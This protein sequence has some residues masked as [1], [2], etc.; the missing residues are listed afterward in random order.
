MS[1]VQRTLLNSESAALVVIDIQE[2]LAA[3]MDRRDEVVASTTRLLKTAAMLEMPIIVTRQ[4]PK[5]LGGTVE[6]IES[7]L[8][9]LAQEGANVVGLDK[10]AFCCAREHEF[11]EALA[12]AGRHQ[13]LLA[14]METHICV[15]QTA[16]AIADEYQVHIPHD[17]CCSR[18]QRDHDV[19]LD[20][21]RSAGVVVTTSESAM[22]EA[23]GVAGTPEFKKL[24]AIVKA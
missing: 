19:A 23:V 2:R 3:V 5:G 10:M 22:Y 11:T 18:D 17:A 1:E 24:L 21:L 6:E 12:A 7:L 13:V 14:G 20:R 16:L 8:V 4:Y 9:E 15:A